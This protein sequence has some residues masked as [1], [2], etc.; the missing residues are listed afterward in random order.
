MEL[1]VFRHGETFSTRDRV[2]YGDRQNEGILSEGKEAVERIAEY[3]KEQKIERWYSSPFKRCIE[4]MDLVMK[5]VEEKYV[6]DE[7]LGEF[8]KKDWDLFVEGIREFIKEI[9]ESGVKK[10][11]VCTHGAVIAGIKF[12]WFDKE[13]FWEN[14]HLYPD[15]GIVLVMDEYGLI[16]KNFR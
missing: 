1:F 16:E 13:F 9:R 6:T 8:Y 4:T 10:V 2:G 5:T 15:P 7:R 14:V 11:G 12:L 3:L